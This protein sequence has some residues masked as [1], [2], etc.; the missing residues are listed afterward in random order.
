MELECIELWPNLSG[1]RG[2]PGPIIVRIWLKE[3][4]VSSV[5]GSTIEEVITMVPKYRISEGP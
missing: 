4:K 2:E 3:M 5:T 1:S